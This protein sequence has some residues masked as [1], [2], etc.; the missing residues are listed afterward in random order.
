MSGT[1]HE[2]GGRRRALVTG[3]SSGIGRAFAERLAADDWDLVV[4]ARRAE[5][6]HA[7]ADR[8]RGR[9]GVEVAVLPADLA[10]SAALAR[11]EDVVR[12]D[13]RL[14]LLVNNAGFGTEGAF[15]E[16]DVARETELVRVNVEAVLRL[17]HAALGPMVRRGRGA[18][19]NV[20][21]GLAFLPAPFFASYGASKAFVTSF[22]EAI[23]EELAGTGVRVQALCPGLTRTEF[24]QVSGTDTARLPGFLWQE[25]DEVAAASLEGLRRGTLVVV[26]GLKNRLPLGLVRG[27]VARTLGRRVLGALSRRGIV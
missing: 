26:P 6:L 2:E 18:V 25:A 3:A 15:H 17:T 14:E 4:V 9:H 23:A 21:S 24:Q 19:I 20:S 12:T 27:A 1:M 5:A 11:V 10:D 8:L 16:L 7:L 13:R 22:T